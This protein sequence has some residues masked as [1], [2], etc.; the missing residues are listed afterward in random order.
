MNELPRCK[1]VVTIIPAV[2]LLLMAS[3]VLTSI[4]VYAATKTG[5]QDQTDYAGSASCKQCHERFYKLWGSSHH[6]LAMQP[7]TA[8]FAGKEVTSQTD[9]I[10]IGKYRYQ[11]RI[12]AGFGYVQEN[13]PD[14][15]KQHP[16]RH[17]MGGKNVYYFLTPLDRG[18][19]QTLPIAY[20]VN[21]KRWFD[22][23]ASG[24]RHFPGVGSD[25]PV[26]WT[27]PLYK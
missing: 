12:E 24:V 1:F 5:A 25:A 4:P 7:Y 8:K 10:T 23:A 19:L 6:G 3:L 26:H 11:A 2:L 20:D 22:T 27:D 17:V 13:G 18:R 15:E 21:K 9:D 16:I 14:G